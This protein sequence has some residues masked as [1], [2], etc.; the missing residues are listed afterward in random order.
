[1]AP[2][3]NGPDSW[4]PAT[5]DNINN[6]ALTFSAGGD[7]HVR[8][9]VTPIDALDALRRVG[10]NFTFSPERNQL[11]SGETGVIVTLPPVDG[12]VGAGS[13]VDAGSGS[14]AAGASGAPVDHTHCQLVASGHKPHWIPVLK[15]INARHGAEDAWRQVEILQVNGKKVTFSTE[16]GVVQ[17]WYHDPSLLATGKR[18]HPEFHVLQAESGAVAVLAHE[19][20]GDCRA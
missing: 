14:G 2:T 4:L 19:P 7:L 1:M 3:P 15:A 10:M 18:Y 5:I 13:T 20:I 11:R 9:F 6:T 16:N 17:G 12:G 8:R